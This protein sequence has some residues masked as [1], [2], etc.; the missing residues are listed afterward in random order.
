VAADVV[1]ILVAWS[2]T[3]AL[4]FAAL[5]LT[6]H[7][8]G[9]P[10]TNWDGEWYQ[11]IAT[12]G[13]EY[14]PDGRQ[15][16]VAF[17][18]L[19]PLT[20]AALMRV[21]PLPFG[22]AAP[23]VDNL[24]FLLALGSLFAWLSRRCDRATARWSVA[25][26]CLLPASVFT[27]V[28]YSEGLFMFLSAS[29]LRAFERRAYR[30]AALFAA[31]A[32]G[33]RSFGVLLGPA[34]ALATRREAPHPSRAAY[35]CALGALVGPLAYA[36]YCGLAFGDPLAFVHVQA[37]WRIGLGFSFPDWEYVFAYGVTWRWPLQSAIVAASLGWL[38]LRAKLPR[39]V[40]RTIVFALAVAEL[41]IWGKERMIFLLLGV[42]CFA[43]VRYRARLGIAA[44][45]YALSALA[46]IVF[47]G[48]PY[49]AER[50]AYAVVP[51]ACALALLW[52]RV[53]ALGLAALT[54]GLVDLLLYAVRFAAGIFVD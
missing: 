4:I 38:L 11:R 1:F 50:L 6:A 3:R 16:D 31:L 10:L 22:I 54:V 41:L 48:K 46:V 30:R 39:R 25:T 19:Y 27:A 9:N 2:A 8:A 49:S 34:F 20:V 17:F 40:S 43:L 45:A 53:P 26:L 14:S 23:L 5:F 24:A 7:A 28:A 15:H 37:A 12:V 51:I 36:S 47:S 32:S 21:V 35:L 13:Y 18:P 44:T 29:A 42:G 33:T 52:R